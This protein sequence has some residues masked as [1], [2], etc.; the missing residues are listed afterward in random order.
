MCMSV[1]LA[2]SE[3]EGGQD[4]F[5]TV[6]ENSSMGEFIANLTITG[7]L[8][9]S[10]VNLSLSGDDADWFFLDGKTIKLNSSNTRI[11]DRE[12]REHYYQQHC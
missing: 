4:V 11:L 2:A 10:H 12:V 5:T 7:D 1:C 9:G 8:S 6:K 3:C